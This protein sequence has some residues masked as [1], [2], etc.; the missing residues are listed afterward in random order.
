MINAIG[1]TLK[2]GDIVYRGARQ[3]NT[4]SFRVGRILKFNEANNTARCQ[5]LH[6]LSGRNHNDSS[7]DVGSIVLIDLTVEQVIDLCMKQNDEI[8]LAHPQYPIKEWW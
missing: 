7:V 3:G 6:D 4:S 2:V 1:Q 8:R 5:W